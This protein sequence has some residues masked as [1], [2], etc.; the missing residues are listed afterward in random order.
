MESTKNNKLWL[1]S[2]GK[3]KSEEEIKEDCKSWGLDAWNEYLENFEVGQRENTLEVPHEIE[4]FTAK[5]CTELLFSMASEEKYAAL[6][7][8]LRGCIGKLTYTQQQFI[9]K[10]YWEGLS[11]PKIAQE[12]GVSRQAVSKIL[13][14]AR[15]QIKKELENGSIK[16]MAD[17]AKTLMAS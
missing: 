4:N 8:A 17:L 13:K 16:K 15:E 12:H 7:Y 14:A 11:I 9:H 1:D 2:K 6:K 3:L 5:E 10:F